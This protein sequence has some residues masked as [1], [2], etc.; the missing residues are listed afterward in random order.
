MRPSLTVSNRFVARE[1][2]IAERVLARLRRAVLD[3]EFGLGEWL[4]EEKLATALGVSRTPV[5]EALN[6]LQAEGLIDVQPQ[7][8]TFVFMPSEGDLEQLCQF[9]QTIEVQ[10]LRLCFLHRREVTLAQLRQ[11]CQEMET[12][13]T[14]GDLLGSAR[15]DTAFHE[16]FLNNCANHYL[17]AS[18]RLASGKIAVLRTHRSSLDTRS[19]VNSEH[20]RIIEAFER[21]DLM[22]AEAM[23]TEHILKML[24]RY[25]FEVDPARSIKRRQNAALCLEPLA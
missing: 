20:M 2:S 4:S 16:T 9:R 25:R 18:Y 22:Q 5:R 21:G 6:A 15:A 13:S 3:G 7:R 10:A 12:A 1:P 24:D 8:G 23:L 17:L 11:A 19:G 14:K